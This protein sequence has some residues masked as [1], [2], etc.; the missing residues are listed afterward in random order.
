MS[1]QS[2]RRTFL[3]AASGAT[4]ALPL[5]E[6]S[7]SRA[8]AATVPQRLIIF[9]TGEGNLA[10][11]WSPPAM[12]QDGLQLSEMLQPL[13]AHKSKMVVVSGIS[14][15]IAPLHTSNGHNAPGHTLMTA[16]LIDTTGTGSFNANTAV[17]QGSLCLGPS[18]DHYLAD[19]LKVNPPINLALGSTNPGENRMWYKVKPAGSG[20]ANPEA[21]LNNDPVKVFQTYLAGLIPGA[22]AP[23][24]RADRFLKQR[25]SVLDG[26]LA[27]F[28]AL[29][30]KVGT[31]DNL[32]LQAH[33]DAIRSIETK[34]TYVPPVQCGGLSQASP[35]NWKLPSDPNFVG[36]DVQANLMIDI[37]VNVLTCG[38]NRIMT[39]QDTMYDDP[40]FEFLPVGPL[41][42][43]H[44][45]VH[46]D[47]ALGLGYAS[48][49]ANPKLK[50]GFLYYASV[51]NRLLDKMD[52]V[53]EPNGLTLLDNS[54]VLWISEFGTGQTHSVSNLP[55]VMAGGAQGK[56]VTNRH[57]PRPSSTTG[58]LFTSILNTFGVPTTSFGYNG[59]SGLNNGGIPG[60]VT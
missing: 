18:I 23:T 31:S 33:A 49:D 24:T 12:A 20:G 3:R 50:A 47:P 52:A 36:M 58:D 32:R 28:T 46:N 19:Q 34:M 8:A 42:G 22:I 4:L 6:S 40:H 30:A 1:Y 25:G 17:E 48:N 56:I 59:M 43:W 45:Q 39:L 9:Q 7:M 29:K 57:L 26:V 53:I 38:A 10:K 27:S 35:A 11:L 44:A 51:F 37:M 13:L 2:T 21:P 41:S 16:S 14:N 5:L 55:V 60:L 54:L 15:K